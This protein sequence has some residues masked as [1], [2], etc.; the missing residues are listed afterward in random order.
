MHNIH[1]NLFV[2]VPAIPQNHKIQANSLTLERQEEADPRLLPSAN[3]SLISEALYNFADFED[4]KLALRR[5]STAS[6]YSLVVT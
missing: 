4:S 6:R 5:L 3:L 1:Y 2:S